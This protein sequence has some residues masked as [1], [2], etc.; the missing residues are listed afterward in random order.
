MIQIDRLGI[1][2]SKPVAIMLV[3]VYLMQSAA[4]VYLVQDKYELEKQITFQQ[5]RMREL[6]ERLE[7]LNAIEGL[8]IGFN[9]QEV[10]ELST[11]IYEEANAYGLDPFF[12]LSVILVESSFK[13]GQKSPVGALGLMQV[14]PFVGEDVAQRSGLVEWEGPNT[15]FDYESNIRIGMRHLF[16]QIMKFEDVNKALVAYNMGETRLRNLM[17]RDVPLPQKYLQ[18]VITNYTMLKERYRAA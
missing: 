1:Y 5:Q 15:L 17:R 9:D 12:V 16:E 7:I 8:Q 2:I 14:M 10:R 4:L 3:G 18:R 11:I 6:E 13:R